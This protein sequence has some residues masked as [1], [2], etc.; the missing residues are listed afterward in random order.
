MRR[1][2]CAAEGFGEHDAVTGARNDRDP[3]CSRRF[4]AG[5]RLTE[6]IDIGVDVEIRAARVQAGGAHERSSPLVRAGGEQHTLHAGQRR[7]QFRPL[8]EREVRD[9][10]A[11]DA[12]QLLKLRGIASRENWEMAAAHCF[13]H[14][15]AAGR[16]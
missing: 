16:P 10:E 5:K 1:T 12:L 13:V 2:T 8:L 7:A 6:V 11:G 15:Q 9:F 4:V 3:G 14:D